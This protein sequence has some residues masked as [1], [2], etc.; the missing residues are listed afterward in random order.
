M[1]SIIFN[2][3]HF[4]IA[5]NLL[6]CNYVFGQAQDAAFQKTYW[7]Y[8]DRFKKY[9]TKIFLVAGLRTMLARCESDSYRT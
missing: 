4:L 2:R 3:K 1:K 8:R 7:E 9:F 5:L 6:V